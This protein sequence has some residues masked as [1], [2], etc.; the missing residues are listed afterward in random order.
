[1]ANFKKHVTVGAS[2]G[3]G[4]NL[5]WQISKILESSKSPTGLWDLLGRVDYLEI[6]TFAAVGATCAALPDILEP[7]TSPNHR[8]LFHSLACGGAMT[9]GAFGKHTTAWDASK[10]FAVQ[11]AALSYLSHLVLD[12]VT[13]KGLPLVS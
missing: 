6:A 9:Y 13:P 3:A 2:V 5:L 11:T 1:M 4:V 10:R 7:A 8:A 12:G